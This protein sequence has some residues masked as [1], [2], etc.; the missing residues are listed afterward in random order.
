[1]SILDTLMGRPLASEEDRTERLGILTG[2]P[3]F[4]L[5]ALSSAAYGPEAA[6]TILLGVGLASTRYVLPLSLIIILLLAIVYFSYRQTIEAYPGGGGSYTVAGQNLGA[7]AGLLA[8]AALMIDYL[9]TAAV[10]ISA[11]VGALVSAAPRLQPHTL[12]LCLAILV[13]L[14]AVNL[15]G[16]REAGVLFLIPTY[17]YIGC[18]LAV[19][20]WGGVQTLLAG[21]HPHAVVPPPP[22]APAVEMV[23]LWLLIRAF[24]SGC[25][26]I[27]GVE[28]VSNGVS[29]FQE[30]RVQTARRT[31]GITVAT[32]VVLLAGIGWLVR[33]YGITATDPGQPG[34]Q[35]VLSMLTAAVAG[36]NWFYG[37]T[38]GAILA[39]LALSANTAFADFPRLCHLIADDN[40]LPAFFGIR[41]RRLVYNVGILMLASAVAV[42][43]IAFRGV[44]DRLIPLYA[45]GAFLAF[46]LS[47]AGMVR[48]WHKQP[49][50]GSRSS[51]WFNGLGA[52]ATGLTV[53]VVVVAKFAAGAWIVVIAIPLLIA[54]M[55]LVHR[56]YGAV[57][58]RLAVRSIELGGL[59]PPVVVVPV[60][61]W[62][63][64]T[65]AALRFSLTITREVDVV[66]ISTGEP[67]DDQGVT[68]RAC[69]DML[70]AAAAEQG[71]PP[72]KFTRL[73]S[74]YRNVLRP[75]LDHVLEVE[76]QQPGRLVAVVVPEVVVKHWWEYLLQ[77]NYA[78]AL[79]ALLLLRGNGRIVII[80]VP[81]YLHRQSH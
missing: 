2:I 4:G 41:G 65:V 75:F 55:V 15:R 35:S 31:L 79:K 50:S 33:A 34:Y 42:L 58:R 5:D 13:L 80:D 25:T 21:G 26:A 32:L 39:V 20:V 63:R 23:T 12:A 36:R 77:N 67:K 45:V 66:H 46:T 73:H 16:V 43:L 71:L 40:Y 74:P 69:E 60:R 61:R 38:I 49:G 53:L 70:T 64:A 8:G 30:P 81:W 54:A 37:L 17:L 52:T 27:T 19:I 1:M 44:T 62:N 47:Q 59:K 78:T 28:A 57:E 11:G 51:Q 29:A 14:T 48:R 24:A 72:P 18:L 10:G 9:L 3:T 68:D 76:R 56:H 22:P 6:M 7:G